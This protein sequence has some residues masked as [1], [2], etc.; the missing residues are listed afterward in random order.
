MVGADESAPWTRVFDALRFWL[1]VEVLGLL[2][3]PLCAFVFSRLPGGGLA[4]ARPLGLLV[5][6]YPA[7]LLASVG[8][9]RYRGA[10]IGIGAAALA[11]ASALAW[12]TTPR[13][14][15]RRGTALK[16][17]AAGGALFAAAFF[18]WTL[19]RSF[20]PDV[21]QTEKPMD[22]AFVNS[23]QRSGSLPPPDPWF[24]GHT[25]NYYYYGH[26][27]AAF[28][29]RAAHVGSTAGFNLAV[30]LF[31]ALSA[32]TVFGVASALYLA[33]REGARAPRRSAVL[34][35]L[36]AAAFAVVAGNIAGTVEYLQH[37]SRFLT[38]DWF[39]PSRVIDG[40]ANEF[41]FF[42]FLLADLHAHAMAAPFALLVLAY[43]LQLCLGGP[44]RWSL[45]AVAELLL[46]GLALGALYATNTLD[47]PTALVL[48]ALALVLW[49]SAAGGERRALA[50]A[51]W[52]VAWTAASLLLFLPFLLDYSPET[53]GIGLVDTHAPFTRFARDE[54]LI[55]GLPLWVVLTL[56][57]SRLRMPFRYFAWGTSA[58]VFVLTLLA[59]HRLAGLLLVLVLAAF[60]LY[61]TLSAR[62]A[63]AQRFLWLLVTAGIGLIAVGEFVYVRD[64]FEGTPTYRFN[65][66]FKAGYQAW[67]LFA[68]AAGCIVF[69]NRAWLG[70]RL[71][72]VWGAGLAALVLLAAAYPL[73]GSYARSGG[74][75]ATPTLDGL[76]WLERAAPGDVRAIEW[77]RTNVR[78]SPTVLEAVG[79]D[80]DPR[81]SARISTFT[82]L[83]TV[84]GWAGHEVQW[85][86]DPGVRGRDVARL[87]S[88]GDVREARRLLTRYRV[89]YVVVGSL[90]R[91]AYP[92]RGL[93]KFSRLGR[94]V[95]SAPGT[96]VYRIE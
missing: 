76:G 77:L 30:A 74:F 6:S 42:S 49:A 84:L 32:L 79:P 57:A 87:Y 90:E 5:A 26:Y 9:M 34:V 39:A 68:V 88:M 29:A 66:V 93:A 59:A 62:L 1:A 61:T 71:R 72:A 14:R 89:R 48:G 38:Y 80:F 40:T 94:R 19:L 28:V 15:V 20:A 45:A 37:P 21:W 31:Y 7:W 91:A 18:G 16:L 44:P 95:F 52:F 56:F 86:H 10:S 55:Y 53:K 70:R 69:W 83:P 22:M 12:R 78:G 85:G 50:A 23:I 64:V 67:F 43:S 13:A 65:T 46:A 60:A 58:A 27:L 81:G 41:P 47:Y 51:A 2:A 25:L 11:L 33:G 75:A 54:L 24:S 17:W 4:F 82:G 63:Q 3:L 73:V 35:G 96:V 36:A 8:I 92:R